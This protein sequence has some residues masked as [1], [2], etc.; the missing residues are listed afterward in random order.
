MFLFMCVTVQQISLYQ[1]MIKSDCWL[2]N[3]ISKENQS[4]M[5]RKKNSFCFF[6]IFSKEEIFPPDFEKRHRS[7]LATSREHFCG[8]SKCKFLLY[9]FNKQIYFKSVIECFIFI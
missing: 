8:N 7:F 9:Y 4:K 2:I 1:F 3:I 6:P 5:K